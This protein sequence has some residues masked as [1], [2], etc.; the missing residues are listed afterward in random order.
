MAHK[1][2]YQILGVDK[3]AT[4]DQI[5]KAYRKLAVRYH[6]DNNKNEK[7]AED[8]FKEA[9]EANSVLS[10]PE[11]RK[12]YDKFGE[13]WEHPQ[14]SE[15][16]PEGQRERF[17]GRQQNGRQGKSFSFNTS[18]FENDERY[19]DVFSQFFARQQ[20]DTAARNGE[21]IAAD[22][23]I[24]LEEAFTGTSRIFVLGKEQHRLTLKK[25]VRNGQQLRLRGKGQ[26][27]ING[28]NPG[29]LLINIRIATH[30]RYTRTGNDLRC[31]QT[32]DL[33]TAVLGGKTRVQTL[34][35]EKM[36]SLQAETQ[37]G[38]TMRMR[39]L[40]MPDYEQPSV[41]GDLYVEVLVQIPSQ[42]TVEERELYGKL[43][44]LK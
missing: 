24:T 31:Q 12:L 34:H 13:H 9:N 6:P 20:D 33:L 29:D 22:V 1:D 19:E 25:G 37:Y 32:V 17:Y 7:G 15:P 8:K 44:A 27:G 3:K 23:Q 43:A 39:G 21:N 42:L 11:K 40:G 35:G 38:A 2:F 5:K 14:Y 41:F 4:P 26:P 16:A 18:D 28:G 36:M 30:L 10:D